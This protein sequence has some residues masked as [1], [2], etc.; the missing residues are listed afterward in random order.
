MVHDQINNYYALPPAPYR[1]H[2]PQSN[3]LQDPAGWDNPR[4][5]TAGNACHRRRTPT[6]LQRTGSLAHTG[7]TKR[8]IP[9]GQR[10]V[11]VGQTE[12]GKEI[13]LS[14]DAERRNFFRAKYPRTSTSVKR[15]DRRERNPRPAETTALGT[16]IFCQDHPSHTARGNTRGREVHK[17][18]C[19]VL[20]SPAL[21]I[22]RP[23]R[24][25]NFSDT[26]AQFLLR[27]IIVTQSATA[28]LRGFLDR[29]MLLHGPGN[30]YLIMRTT[31]GVVVVQRS[32]L[33]R[34]AIAGG[35]IESNCE[36]DLHSTCDV[37][38]ETGC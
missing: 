21:W 38:K 28:Y 14:L 31:R 19:L 22:Q 6:H 26:A 13:I 32:N 5:R 34:I 27:R 30:A 1:S 18:R 35:I 33:P 7:G 20:H 10:T 12:V 23:R 4:T 11:G 17:K 24:Q 16:K 3:G 8:R 9:P 25:H 36:V 2:S 37:V 15:K 29:R